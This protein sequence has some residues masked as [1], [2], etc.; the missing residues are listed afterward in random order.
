MSTET[1]PKIFDYRNVDKADEFEEIPVLDMGPY[2]AGEPGAAEELAANIRFIQE[3]I[4]FYVVINHG[5][6]RP[7]IDDAYGALKEFF[8]LSTEDKAALKFDET[9]VGYIAPKSTV[10]VTSKINENT[11]QDLNETLVLCLDRP[12]DHPY[13]RDGVRFTGPNKWPDIEG[14]REP[15]VRYQYACADLGRKIVPLYALALDKPIDFFDKYFE[16][17]IMWTRNAHYPAVEAEENQFG[18]SPHSDHSFLTILPLTRV[19]GLQVLTHQGN[20]LPASFNK[21]A[22][23][24]NTGEFLNLW[25]NGRFIASPHRVIPPAQ[26]RYSMATFF[27]AAPD[28]LAD[29]A[30]FA[31]AGEELK[32]E[33][34]TMYDYVCGYIDQNYSSKAGGK[35]EGIEPDA[36]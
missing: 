34:T 14:F 6:D 33:P 12:D 10:Y 5:I 3:T 36:A 25:S 19:A 15:M 31:E 32:Y 21:D 28:T 4:G 22:L 27:D 24:I 9:S 17:P 7:T 35:A 16:E 18:I 23:V 11:K 8:K 1:A 2:L 29:P 26:D 13:V 30:D 20:W